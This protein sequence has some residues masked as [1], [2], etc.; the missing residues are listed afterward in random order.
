MI[1]PFGDISTLITEFFER[2]L[3]PGQC[4]HGCM[5]P[6]RPFTDISPENGHLVYQDGTACS[7]SF[8]FS[9]VY[10]TF[11]QDSRQT[12]GQ[13]SRQNDNSFYVVQTIMGIADSYP[14]GDPGEHARLVSYQCSNLID[15]FNHLCAFAFDDPNSCGD[16]VTTILHIGRRCP[17]PKEIDIVAIIN[18]H[19]EA[20]EIIRNAK[21]YVSR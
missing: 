19:P 6:G 5:T 2:C 9:D 18:Q 1:Q 21:P 4:Y 15:V 20:R 8:A 11:G 16:V 12:F 17:F 10:Q 14:G 3:K 7:G 13:D